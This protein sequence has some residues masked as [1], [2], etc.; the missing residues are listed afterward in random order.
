MTPD[1]KKILAYIEP[2]ARRAVTKKYLSAR[3]GIPTRKIERLIRELVI[4]YGVE[5]ASSCER[6]FGYFL[7][8]N[9]AEGRR[10]RSQLLS[11]MKKLNERLSA[12]DKITARKISETLQIEIFDRH[13]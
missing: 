5:I 3:T 9:E 1:H 2:G 11:R 13:F 10:Y 12:V 7:I 6:P 8:N 4:E